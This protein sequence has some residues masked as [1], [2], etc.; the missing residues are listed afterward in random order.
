MRILIS[1]SEPGE[2]CNRPCTGPSKICV[3][4]FEASVGETTPDM[5]DG[6]VREFLSFNKILPGPLLQVC[7]GD[8]VHVNLFNNIK[9]N[10]HLI[11]YC[12][13]LSISIYLNLSLS[14][15]DRDKADTIISF[16]HTITPPIVIV[17]DLVRQ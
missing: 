6:R 13:A 11:N 17:V 5:A 3:F 4:E 16:H 10:F 2:N 7:E 8:T 14:L 1:I 15:R 12:Q 9:V